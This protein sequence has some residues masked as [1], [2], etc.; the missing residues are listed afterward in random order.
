[1]N[2]LVFARLAKQFSEYKS[3]ID[4]E[5]NDDFEVEKVMEVSGKALF[6]AIESN[7]I[8][9]D[10]MP[11]WLSKKPIGIRTGSDK[12]GNY[13]E[14]KLFF[15]QTYWW[16]AIIWLSKHIPDSTIILPHKVRITKPETHWGDFGGDVLPDLIHPKTT[17]ETL[18]RIWGRIARASEAACLFIADLPSK[19]HRWPTKEQEKKH[20][21]M[22]IALLIKK[23]PNAKLK[24]IADELKVSPATISRSDVWHMHKT[25]PSKDKFPDH[26]S[27]E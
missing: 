6:D 1:M 13:A 2:L 18:G 7:K 26:T 15:W 21:D 16:F 19:Q 25:K 14:Y 17:D 4:V 10:N 8:H 3:N 23:N 24:E 12:N 5:K 22:E 9:F 11:D 20:R 27:D